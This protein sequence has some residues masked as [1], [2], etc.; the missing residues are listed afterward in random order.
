MLLRWRVS[1]AR[2]GI[3]RACRVPR[4]GGWA[5]GSGDSRWRW[6]RSR[7]R[8]PWS[9]GG[10]FHDS[11][12]SSHRPHQ[13]GWLLMAS[14]SPNKP[15]SA[16]YINSLVLSSTSDAVPNPLWLR[17][18]FSRLA[19]PRKGFMQCTQYTSF[20]PSPGKPG[21]DDLPDIVSF[22]RSLLLSVMLRGPL[23]PR[24]AAPLAFRFYAGWMSAAA[25][26]VVRLL[27]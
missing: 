15:G 21:L 1:G 10:C 5:S 16:R 23:T 25:E 12:H 13:W 6:F 24:Q 11:P 22:H 20:S 14:A 19:L 18:S 2:P 4:P 27:L 9:H 7:R 3:P 17:C 26:P 8:C